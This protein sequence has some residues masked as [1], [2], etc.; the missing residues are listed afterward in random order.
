MSGP[1]RILTE[2]FYTALRREVLDGN[3]DLDSP[4][5][6]LL[7]QH[8]PVMMQPER[9]PPAL[10]TTIYVQ[11]RAPAVASIHGRIEARPAD[12][13]VLDA[14][15]GYGSESFLFA[16]LGAQVLAVDLEEAKVDIARRR[17][18]FWEQ[19]FG[20]PLAIEWQVAN[21][22]TYAPRTDVDFTWIASVL[23]NVTD[24]DAFLRRIHTN[25]R[26]GGEVM[27]TDM[28][29]LN[30][31]FLW[32]EWRRRRLA[33]DRS[34]D[35]ARRAKFMDMVRR[36]GRRGARYYSI[37]APT[38]QDVQDTEMFDDAQFF[39]PSTLARLFRETGFAPGT[40]AFSGFMPPL[41]GMPGLAAVE[42]LLASVP[43]V[44]RG[45]Y[46]YRMSGFKPQ[47]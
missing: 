21:L 26:P 28:N 22:D 37:D 34:P 16:A 36:R 15:C 35:F 24:Q 29:L 7:R 9:Y 10:V 44:R 39:T 11:R 2:A 40:P 27:I 47:G 18:A 30:P 19:H 43:L 3:P 33:F 17:Q 4:Q 5:Q 31:L 42:G 32:G 12:V 13:V 20:R 6:T 25:T 23:A 41:P 45:G 1:S 46:F 38:G 8:Y 14:G